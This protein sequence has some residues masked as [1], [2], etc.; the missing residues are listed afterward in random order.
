MLNTYARQRTALRLAFMACAIIASS[1]G[2]TGI[3]AAEAG[4]PPSLSTDAIAPIEN[5]TTDIWP[6]RGWATSTPEAQGIDSNALAGALAAIR[7]EHLPVHSLLIERHGRIVLDAYFYPFA[8]NRLHDVTSVTKSVTSTLVGIALG[9]RRLNDLNAPVLTFF[10]EETAAAGDPRKARVTLAQ[11]LSMT[12]GIDCSPSAGRSF[13]Q[14]M[15]G[16]RHWA[17][18]A[19]DRRQAAEPGSTFAYCAGNMELLSA[20]LTRS[21]GTS[22]ATFAQ[23]ELFAPL[24]IESAVWPSDADGITHGFSD[25][26]LE[27]RDM[28]K[29]GYLWLHDG[30]WDGK[31]IVPASYLRAARTP[32]AN[33]AMNTQYGY[34]MWI[35]P[36]C[37]PAGGAI[38]FEADGSNGQRIAVIPSLD[39]VEVITGSGLDAN[40]VSALI[41][42]VA[43]SDMALPEN[44]AGDARLASHVA[45]V[46]LA[47]AM[48]LAAD[49]PAS[50][51]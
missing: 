33:V 12:S 11:L 20:V 16:S 51:Y 37:G 38:D 21:T 25:L 40:A 23:R 36:E 30:V 4:T 26:R 45:A 48:K 27:P 49:I 7:A 14:Q 42:D 35:H 19:L 34:G 39:M 6:T 15:E 31:Q 24:G 46:A 50:N 43:K 32:Y 29:L 41:V 10:P 17:S 47:P 13:L 22:A 3:C 9:A 8:N 1:F 18:F 5:A 44:P 2:E 28:A